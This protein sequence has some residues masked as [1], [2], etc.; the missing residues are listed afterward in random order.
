[1][2]NFTFVHLFLLI[3]I[4]NQS[5]V[6]AQDDSPQNINKLLNNQVVVSRQIMCVLDRSP[7]DNLGKQLKAALPEV[8]VRNC[9]NC[10][11]QQA[12]NAQKLISF[13]Q[14]RYPDVWAMLVRKYRS[15]A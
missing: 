3:L 8:I 1:M 15:K 2:K 6:Y 5:W 9:K 7:C 4:I 13:L 14:T 10:T 12:Q 11:K